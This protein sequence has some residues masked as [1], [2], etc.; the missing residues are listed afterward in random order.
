M[1][2][3]DWLFRIKPSV[4]MSRLCHETAYF[5]LPRAAYQELDQFIERVKAPAG[6]GHYYKQACLRL[7]ADPAA[8]DSSR[9]KWHHGFWDGGREYFAL[10]YPEPAALPKA[11]VEKL[12]SMVQQGRLVLAPYYSVIVRPE[13]GSA[14][15]C[16]VL[17]QSPQGGTELGE[18]APDQYTPLGA[19]PEPRLSALLEVLAERRPWRKQ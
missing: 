17:A 10:Q 5:V 16:F 18:V 7:K 11:P 4:S 13:P 6:A 9:F 14:A 3:L 12:Q 15:R 19:G 1:G 8:V 2:F